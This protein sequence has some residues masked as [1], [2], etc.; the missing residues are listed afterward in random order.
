MHAYI[1]RWKKSCMCLT[2]VTPAMLNIGSS[3]QQEDAAHLTLTGCGINTFTA[4]EVLAYAAPPHSCDSGSQDRVPQVR[5]L[6]VSDA[7]DATTSPTYP[8]AH[9]HSTDDGHAPRGSRTMVTGRKVHQRLSAAIETP[10]TRAPGLP[11]SR[12]RRTVG[13]QGACNV[14]QHVARPAQAFEESAFAMANASG[15]PEI[16]PAPRLMRPT[17]AEVGATP[18]ASEPLLS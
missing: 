6:A 3:R 17:A 16:L 11:P 13:E 7:D 15:G 5:D 10:A 12:R 14:G 8:M 18:R 2:D 9:H 4:Q 1:I